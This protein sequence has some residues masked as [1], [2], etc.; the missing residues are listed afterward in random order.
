MATNN[1]NSMN[2]F[3]FAYLMSQL[4]MT[5]DVQKDVEKAIMALALD[6]ASRK[7]YGANLP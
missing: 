6:V 1:L 7:F 4:I 2:S 3:V 5:I